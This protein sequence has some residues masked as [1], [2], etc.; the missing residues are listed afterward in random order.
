MPGRSANRGSQDFSVGECQCQQAR[1]LIGNPASLISCPEG[2]KHKAT[3]Q[4]KTCLL[5][6]ISI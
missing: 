3:L 2:F 5:N 4:E 6:E 1:A